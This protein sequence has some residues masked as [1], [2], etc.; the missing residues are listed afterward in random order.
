MQVSGNSPL[1]TS[2][3]KTTNASQKGSLKIIAYARAPFKQYNLWA[4]LG[5]RLLGDL[6][7]PS[8]YNAL[9]MQNYLIV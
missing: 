2:S 3:Q 7:R 8:H 5:Q 6:A 1:E 9:P 4:D